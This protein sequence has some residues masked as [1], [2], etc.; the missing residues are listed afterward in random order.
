MFIE[1][2]GIENKILTFTS[3]NS[4]CN[5]SVVDHLKE[6]S[7]LMNLL[8]CDGKFFHVHYRNQILNLTVK[9]GLD[10][11]DET[12]EKVREGSKHMKYSK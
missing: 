3:E 7:Y 10:K 12:I 4:S 1:E 2:W 8:V 11:V 5:E 6:H 9:A